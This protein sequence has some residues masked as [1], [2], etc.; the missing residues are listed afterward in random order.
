MSLLSPKRDRRKSP[1]GSTIM[2]ALRYSNYDIVF[3][4]VP[5]EVTL[6]INITGCPHRCPGCHSEYLWEYFGEPLLND[7]ESII[8]KYSGMIT[9]VALMGG[10]QNIE[11][12]SSALKII[13]SYGLKTCVYFGADTMLG[14]LEI[15]H[16]LD[17]LKIGS[18]KAELGGLDSPN[19]NQR[20][21]NVQD[22]NLVDTTAQFYECKNTKNVHSTEE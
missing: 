20:F 4:E 1:S 12:A 19:T 6:A 18:Y 15:V 3:Q 9:C 7:L 14:I 11:D 22:G 5:G 2:D 16:D 10:D 21:Y 13:K 17:Y 8:S